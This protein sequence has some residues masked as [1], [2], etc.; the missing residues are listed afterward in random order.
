MS[1]TISNQRIID[2]YTNNKSIDIETVNLLIID[3]IDPIINSSNHENHNS[4]HSQVLSKIGELSSFMNDIQDSMQSSITD[5]LQDLKKDFIEDLKST[6]S[7]DSCS[8]IDKFN[9]ILITNNEHLIDKTNLMLNNIIPKNDYNIN[10]SLSGFLTMFENKFN[11]SFQPFYSI[12]SSSEERIHKEIG[13]L[14]QNQLSD[15]LM[16]NLSTFFDKFKNSSHKGQLGEMQLCNVLN[17]IF[18]SAE[19]INST[20]LKASCDFQIK[21]DKK[22]TILI[23]TKDYERNVALDEVKKFIR[24]IDVQKSHGIFLSQ[25]SGITSKQN[26]QI[27]VHQKIIT[28]YIHYVKYDP[29]IIKIAVDIID[30]LS[31]KINMY[32]TDDSNE[33]TLSQETIDVIND[34]YSQFVSKRIAISEYLKDT[35]KKTLAQLDDIKL[36]CLTRIL[37]HKYGKFMDENSNEI[38]CNICNKF[39]ASSNR[40]LAAHQRG[41]KK[42]SNDNS[43]F[44]KT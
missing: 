39:S 4:F 40:A 36:P 43:I 42:K 11:Q 25:H 8:H 32:D 18:P 6:I 9:S 37:S 13:V 3:L 26:F 30:H 20:S 7:L 35:H 15:H 19:I 33:I 24:D 28:L 27:D 41:C 31:S 1:I 14:K 10:E 21:R 38:V 44:V 34:E 12:I 23:E 2:F 22:D 29:T 17:Q 16:E 5:K